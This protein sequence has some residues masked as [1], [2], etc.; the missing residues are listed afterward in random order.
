MKIE[1][2]NSD[3]DIDDIRE[4][5]EKAKYLNVK[6]DLEYIKKLRKW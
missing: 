2:S 1:H 4:N 3:V 5:Y 6:K